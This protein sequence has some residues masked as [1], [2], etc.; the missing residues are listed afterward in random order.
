[1]SAVPETEDYCAALVPFWH[2]LMT[3]EELGQGP[4]GC[5]LLGRPLTVVR[6]AEGLACLDDVCRHLGASLSLGE[7]VGAGLRCRYHGWTYDRAGRCVDIPARRGVAIPREARVRSY[8]VTERYGLVW[9]SLAEEPSSPIP[10]FP[11]HGDERYHLTLIRSYGEWRASAPRIV[12]GALDDT[13]FPWVHP[14]LLGDPAHPEPPD[15]E[16][17]REGDYL[18][19][20]YSTLQPANETISGQETSGELE[21]VTYTNWCTP[22]TIR[23]RKDGPAGTYAIYQVMC[24]VSAQR[25]LIFLQMA[26]DFDRD[27]ARDQA[28]LEFEDVIQAQDRPVIESQRPWLLPP[29]S[30]RLSLYVRPADLPLIA[31]QRWLE[32]LGVPQI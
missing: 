23:L 14:G 22:T 8:P 11:E 28:Y 21:T 25:S 9:A 4:R 19:S 27:P 12:M 15:H 7:V 20:R 30:A 31:F 6:L 13:H 24:P 32:E 10:E 5:E 16:A 29:L 26:R 1:M 2:P 3:V 17:F 18:V